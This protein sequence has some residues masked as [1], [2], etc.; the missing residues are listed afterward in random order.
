MIEPRFSWFPP[1][2]RS[3][4]PDCIA[5]WRAA[6]GSLFGWQEFAIDGMLG[7]DENDHFVS[8]DDG[9]CVARQNGKGVIEQALEV[10]FAFE[11]NYLVVMHTAHEFATS[12][13][14]QLRLEAFIQDCPHL[15]AK[16]RGKGGYVHANGQESIRLKSGCRIIFKAR[17]KGGGRGYSGDLLVWD[18]GMVIPSV[19]VGAQKPMLR[20]SQAAHGPKTIYA[21]SAVDQEFHEHGVPFALIRER[22]I[23]KAPG[24]SYCE[25]SAPFDHPDDM[26]DEILR[27]RSWWPLAN[28]A[29]PE[30][31]ILAEHMAEEIESMPA[32][33]AAVELACVGDWPRTDGL[34][35]AV[36]SLETWM[37]LLDD[38]SEPE[39]PVCFT[40][41]V[42]PDRRRAAVAVVGKRS[43]GRVH[44][45][46][47]E[48][49]A[50]TGWVVP[51]L[52]RLHK[53][54]H[55][56]AI[57]CDE[58]SP[59]AALIPALE[60]ANLTIEK[61]N[62]PLHAQACGLFFDAI[63]QDRFRHRGDAG[64]LS[65]VKGAVKRP[66]GERWAWSRKNSNVDI[67]PLVAVTLGVGYVLT[68]NISAPLV[69]FA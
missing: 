44:G 49:R 57:V 69:A 39:G 29:M 17:T 37:A 55:P 63:E 12:Q 2:V 21:G 24:I 45:E 6:G 3:L 18:E 52:I 65:A 59:A 35:D 53:E 13:E 62:G 10:Y 48:H 34:S 7:L 31:L 14:H 15:H 64:L 58:A 19:V 46:I 30:G 42:T 38:E 41:D 8:G 16:V 33:V 43:D 40:F 1:R 54:H 26:S 5:F 20:A 28:P 47:H 11:L 25:W 60:Q 36:I 66:L 56:M 68:T 32:R 61:I 50:G 22:G 23:A 27:D 9:V 4:G 67:S 51:E